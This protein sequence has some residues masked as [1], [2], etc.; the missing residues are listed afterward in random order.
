MRPG[1]ETYRIIGYV[2]AGPTCPVERFP[3]DPDCADQPVIGAELIIRDA[4]GLE[5]ERLVSNEGGRFQTRL[6][7]GVYELHP[8]PYDGLLGTAPMQEFE[9]DGS[10]LELDVAYDTGIR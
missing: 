10:S 5:M 3:P 2:H 4:A 9:V 7:N 8:Q 6:P 1:N